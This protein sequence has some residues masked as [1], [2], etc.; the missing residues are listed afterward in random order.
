MVDL[1]L[2]VQSAYALGEHVAISVRCQGDAIGGIPEERKLQKLPFNRWGAF[3]DL[4]MKAVYAY[5]V[6]L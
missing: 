5:L 2:S 6:V 3:R 4:L 1:P